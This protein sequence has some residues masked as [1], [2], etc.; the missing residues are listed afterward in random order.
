MGSKWR[1]TLLQQLAWV[2]FALFP[3]ILL[4]IAEQILIVIYNIIFTIQVVPQRKVP[5]LGGGRELQ[6]IENCRQTLPRKLNLSSAGVSVCKKVVS[7]RNKYFPRN[8]YHFI[9]CIFA[10]T[11]LLRFLWLNPVSYAYSNYFDVFPLSPPKVCISIYGNSCEGL[12]IS[13]GRFTQNFF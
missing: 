13:H 11:F 4:L 2:Y 10:T 12:V 1:K 9:C 8:T 6:R 7:V 3:F 5:T